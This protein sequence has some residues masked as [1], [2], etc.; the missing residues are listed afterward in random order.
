M[1]KV[2][3]QVTFLKPVFLGPARDIDLNEATT[4]VADL[5][6]RWTQLRQATT[7]AE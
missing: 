5:E 6:K 7:C 2:P 1:P 4:L 3:Y